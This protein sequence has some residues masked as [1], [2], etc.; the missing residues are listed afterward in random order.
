MKNP[1]LYLAVLLTAHCSAHA[2]AVEQWRVHEMVLSSSKSYSD[3]FRA[4]D[5]DAT[6]VGPNGETIH[7]PAFWDGGTVW[8]VRFAPPTVGTWTYVTTCSDSTNTAFRSARGSVTCVPYK[9]RLP[10]YRHGFLR[11]SAEKRHLCYRDGTPFF[12]LGDVHWLWEQERLDESNKAGWSS[13]F[14]GMA[15]KRSSQGFNLYQVELFGRWKG[16]PIGGAA[17]SDQ[18]ALNLGHFQTQ[19]DPKW[20]YLADNGFVVAATL[21]ILPKNVTPAQGQAEARMARYVCARYGAYPAVWLMFQECTANL[22]S[23][24]ANETQRSNYMDV[25]RSVGNAYRQND[26][27]QQ[28]RTAHSDSSIVTAYRGEDWLDFT[29]F[30]AGH[31]KAISFSRYLDFYFDTGVTIPQIE[32]EADFERL[33]DGSDQNQ[34]QLITVDDVRDKAYRAMQCGCCGYTYGAGGVWQATWD[35]ERTG[36]QTVYGTTPWRD[37]IDLPGGD[38]MS[39]LR[40]FY[41][42]ARWETLL[43]RPACD[44]FLEGDGHLPLQAKPL[45]SS[46]R[47]V[48]MIVVYFPAGRPFPS[49][50][51]HLQRGN[52]AAKWFD[53][54]S[55]T[56][57]LV[58]PQVSPSAGNWHC[59]EKP[60]GRDWLLKLEQ[61]NRAEVSS[62]PIASRWNE[63]KLKQEREAERNVAHQAKVT[64]SSTDHT[65]NVYSPENAIDGNIDTSDWRHWSN[66]SAT[67][68]ASPSHPVWLKL[69][70]DRLVSIGKIVLYTMQGYEVQ[71]YKFEYDDGS[72]WKTVPGT[73]VVGNS[74]EM[75]EHTFAKPILAKR[76]RFVGKRGPDVQPQIVRVVEIEAI[77]P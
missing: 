42:A 13:E 57:R 14:R 29:L 51:H 44:G 52:Y 7:R 31:S 48:S 59:P 56:Y 39:H 4:I 25:V 76:L 68:P 65:Q 61:L 17:S 15:D 40:E 34:S 64:A 2:G 47:S 26:A 27:Y 54:R 73:E 32:G 41:E 18:N 20:K 62:M 12:W 1:I 21:G 33:F 11:V 36:N 67:D 28:P 49:I 30:Q 77:S 45:V 69:E 35:H 46:D 16:S 38:Q 3:P 8:K 23:Q 71:D 37:G 53:P 19:V 75:R 24:F 22:K 5:V 50:L 6:F 58:D 43:P 70:W 72:D 9:G 55:G 66:D 74:S 60:D 63:F 10:I